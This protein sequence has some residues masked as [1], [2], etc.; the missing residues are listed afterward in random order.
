MDIATLIGIV[1][2]FGLFITAMALGG[3]LMAF[4]NTSGLLIV[5]GGTQAAT[6]VN[7]R[8]GHVMSTF[9]IVM[10]A[11]VDRLSD[12]KLLVPRIMEL[13]GKARKEGLVSLENE[14]IDDPFLAR[15]VRLGV[16]GLSPEQ[17]ISM[18]R[19]ELAAL[20][21]RHERGQKILR[22]LGS[23][24]P[25]MGLVGTLIGLVQMLR[26]LDDPAAIGPSMAIA[27]L[28][29]LYGAILAFLVFT[30]LAEKLEKRSREEQE[31]RMLAIAGVESILKGENS[32]VIQSKLEAY[33]PPS[34]RGQAEAS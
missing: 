23:T 20:R 2:G 29:T 3:S 11:F 6:L 12:P 17:V 25:P 26:T 5:V 15:G 28:T 8:L 24:A 27:L 7:E 10:N 1:A 16:D 31:A 18:L 32:L 22:F 13:A 19:T 9:K 34:Q 21:G 33:M 30:P 14:P 4:V